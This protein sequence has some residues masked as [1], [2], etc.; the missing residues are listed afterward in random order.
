M[1]KF[2]VNRT[3]RIQGE[4]NQ[5]QIRMIKIEISFGVVFLIIDQKS[6][7]GESV[8]TYIKM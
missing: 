5:H 6:F 7:S 3:I 1:G 4:K 2:N 8:V